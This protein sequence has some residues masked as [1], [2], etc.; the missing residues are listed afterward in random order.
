M[1]HLLPIRARAGVRCL[2]EAFVAAVCAALAWITAGFV[3]DE[4]AFGGAAFAGVPAWVVL[5][6]LPVG[7]ALMSLRHAGWLARDAKALATGQSPPEPSKAVQPE[8]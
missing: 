3:L 5:L 4:R 2:T 6:A 1:T 7:F 8:P